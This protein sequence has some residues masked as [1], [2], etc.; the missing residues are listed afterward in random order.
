MTSGIYRITSLINGK[1]YIGSSINIEVR[2]KRHLNDLK[3]GYHGNIYLQ[4]IYDKYGEG[5][6]FL[7]ILYVVNN[8]KKLRKKEQELLSQKGLINISRSASGGDLLTDH[9]FR[10]DI[11]ERVAKASR[12]RIALMDVNQR[13]RVFG[14]SGALNGNYGR[15]WTKKQKKEASKR[16]TGRE[17]K[18][19]S[20]IKKGLS[21]RHWWGIEENRRKMCEKRAG[22]GNPFYGKKHTKETKSKLSKRKKMEWFKMTPEERMFKNPQVKKVSIDGVEYCGVG[23]AARAIG[24]CPATIIFRIKSK[25]DRFS[26]YRYV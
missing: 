23:E 10:D 13:K 6:L 7:E 26:S 1:F 19:S 9:P 24:V 15:V 2:W 25:N 17:W 12:L 21:V 22:R 3:R 20:K 14:R 5:N 16:A 8:V 18:E 4:R 11:I